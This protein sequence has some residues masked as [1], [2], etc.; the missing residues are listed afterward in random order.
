MKKAAILFTLI[1]LVTSF[2]S[3]NAE[4]K[5]Y[6]I[7]LGTWQYS[8][9]DAPYPYNEGTIIFKEVDNKLAGEFN[10]QGQ[11]LPVKEVIF[12]NDSVTMKF[13]VEYNPVST[14]LK[15]IDGALVGNADSPNGPITVKA[16]L[17]K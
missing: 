13:E 5:E 14:T 9:P 16:T 7:I 10:I 4:P 17:K 1:L 15:L 2:V 11:V 8:A 6:Q 3:A 12:E